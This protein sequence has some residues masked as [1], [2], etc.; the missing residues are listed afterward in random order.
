MAPEVILGR[1][2]SI[3][4]LTACCSV[5]LALAAP[6]WAAESVTLSNGF[7]VQ[8]HHHAAVQGRVRLFLGAG[9][10]NYLEVNPEDVTSVEQVPDPPQAEAAEVKASSDVKLSAAD[11]GEMLANAGK[12]HNLDV[13]L[14][15][16]VVK[17]ESGGQRPC[18]E[19][20]RSPRTDAVD[21]LDRCRAGRFR[22]F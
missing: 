9:E 20:H 6:A 15:A 12:V 22:Q 3:R 5:L 19:P 11:L 21:A 14:L 10:D 8:C 1:L 2:L 16:S 17:A 13:D 18:R 4:I 7:D